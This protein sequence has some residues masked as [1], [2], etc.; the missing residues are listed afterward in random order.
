MKLYKLVKR[1]P[2][3]IS[4]STW[5]TERDDPVKAGPNARQ[6]IIIPTLV[7]QYGSLAAKFRTVVP[8]RKYAVT[9]FQGM[10][11]AARNIQR[12]P[13][14]G[15]RSL[16]ELTRLELEAYARELGASVIGYTKVNP[17]FIF[18]DFEILY[19]NAMV[20]A[21]EMD[22]D[23]I[24]SGPSHACM[25]EI[26]RTY[27][28]LGVAVN[29]LADWLR[30]RGYNCHPSP[31]MGGDI[32]TVPTAQDANLG[33]VGRNGILITP[34]YGPCVRLTA[35]FI[36]V[37]DLP[38]AETWDHRWVADFCETCLRCAKACPAGAILDEPRVLDDD[39]KVFIDPE[40]CAIPFSEGCSVC[41]SSCPFT[42]GHY[43]RLKEVWFRRHGEE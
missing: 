15:K 37:D 38:M 20:L 25:E 41:I 18:R 28:V 27:A 2:F 29:K 32:N 24:D 33:C 9:C 21:I 35:V 10:R 36:D 26:V 30:E 3:F 42:G 39:S 13:Q 40:K 14:T 34:E 6:A 17:D 11:E 12:N 16:D 1:P 8:L 22:K 31:A 5:I 43:P 23:A 19:D 7:A 4:V